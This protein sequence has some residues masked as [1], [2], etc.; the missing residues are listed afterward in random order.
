MNASTLTA[1][2][3]EESLRLGFDLVGATV[4]TEPPDLERLRQWVADGCAGEMR[5]Y[6]ADRMDAY[7]HP[8]RLLPG[9]KS[10]LMLGLNYRTVEPAE[11][12]QADGMRNVARV[13]RYAWGQDYHE[14]IRPRLHRLADFHRR[15]KPA[16]QTRGVV[17]TAPLLERRFAQLA[18][19]GW[20]GRNGLVIN[21][22]L[23]SWFFLAALLTTEELEYD[24]PASDR[25]GDCRACLDACPTSACGGADCQPANA[26]D[27]EPGG[28]QRPRRCVDARK[29]L[30]YL[31]IESSGP[32]PPEFSSV[33]GGR[34]FGCD[35]CQ[36]VC[37]WNVQTPTTAEP[38]FQPGAGMNPLDVPWLR[39]L[40][41]AAFRSRFRHTP[42]WRAGRENL[43]RNIAAL[44]SSDGM[45]SPDVG[46]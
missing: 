4:A 21:E 17:D 45:R 3:K 11:L 42:L 25:C 7:G 14:V 5:H 31:T 33:C 16:A 23:G 38:A 24:R 27:S 2:L 40:D 15:L 20:I 41:E 13:S 30:S 34:L 19:L 29:C 32:L 43:L 1:A 10:V 28:L 46:H 9:A 8:D 35:A 39:S 6:F 36:E 18:G 22:R 26:A 37:P 12:V 44:E